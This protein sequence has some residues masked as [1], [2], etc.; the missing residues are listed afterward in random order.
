MLAEISARLILE[1]L[2][3]V[4]NIS[5]LVYIKVLYNYW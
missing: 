1:V 4:I 2:A 5:F 3:H